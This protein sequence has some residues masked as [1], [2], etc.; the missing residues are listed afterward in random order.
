MRTAPRRNPEAGS[1]YI[2]ALLVLVV[3]S[4]IGIALA[5]ITQ[6][7]YQIGANELTSNRTLYAAD[8]AFQFATAYQLTNNTSVLNPTVWN[9]ASKFSPQGWTSGGVWTT[10]GG[11]PRKPGLLYLVVPELRVTLDNTGAVQSA[12]NTSFETDTGFSPYAPVN[13]TPCDLC[14]SAEGDVQLV[15]VTYAAGVESMR[16]NSANQQTVSGVKVLYE[17]VGLQ[18]WVVPNW[19]PISNPFALPLVGQASVGADYTHP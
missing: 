15:N 19:D 14:P 7:E 6:T 8:E 18:P 12:G 17:N 13:V 3:L 11:P 2:I 5:Q 9:D 16:L 10:G 1:A 4:I